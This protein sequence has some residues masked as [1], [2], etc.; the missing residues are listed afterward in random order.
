M[1]ADSPA[2]RP[3]ALF[4]IASPELFPEAEMLPHLICSRPI[5]DGVDSAIKEVRYASVTSD[6][7]AGS[8]PDAGGGADNI[9]FLTGVRMPPVDGPK[10][11]ASLCRGNILDRAR[12]GRR[13][14]SRVYPNSI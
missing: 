13:R 9:A 4:R 2:A 3:D 5:F 12:P 1:R 8:I 7:A 6:V 11:L 10:A 14:L